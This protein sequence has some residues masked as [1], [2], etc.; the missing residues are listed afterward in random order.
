MDEKFEELERRLAHAIKLGDYEP[1][2]SIFG[3]N[4]A[5]FQTTVTMPG[6]SVDFAGANGGFD[7]V[8]HASDQSSRT[9]IHNF[10]R[11]LRGRRVLSAEERKANHPGNNLGWDAQKSS[12]TK[13]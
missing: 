5:A 9:K 3:K 2:I 11:Q 1:V 6:V 10:L 7:L 4:S 8:L 13:D 12:D